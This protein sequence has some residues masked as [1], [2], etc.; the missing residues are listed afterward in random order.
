MRIYHQQSIGILIRPICI[1]DIHK[2]SLLHTMHAM[3][4]FDFCYLFGH[5]MAITKKKA[6]QSN[7]VTR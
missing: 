5:L 4:K 3:E 2:K 1:S 7:S 6:G